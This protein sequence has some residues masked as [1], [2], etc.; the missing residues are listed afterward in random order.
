MWQL[1]IAAIPIVG[2]VPFMIQMLKNA[3][4]RIM[5]PTLALTAGGSSSGSAQEDRQASEENAIEEYNSSQKRSYED[6]LEELAKAINE[7]GDFH[8]YG[9]LKSLLEKLNTL[10]DKLVDEDAIHQIQMVYA[11]YNPIL[12]KIVDVTSP[13]YYGDFV[14]N[15]EHWEHPKEM[16]EQ[17]E[18]AV[19][20]VVEEVAE[21]IRKVNS[22]R[23]V[24]FQVSIESLVG[25]SMELPATVSN[26][27]GNILEEAKSASDSR[28][29]LMN[30]MMLT[31]QA[32][33]EKTRA[34]FTAKMIAARTEEIDENRSKIESE[35]K[36]LQTELQGS[37]EVANASGI[38]GGSREEIARFEDLKDGGQERFNK[39][40]N[41]IAYTLVKTESKDPKRRFI[42]SSL[43]TIT[44]A[45]KS[46]H[47]TN[48]FDGA[49]W[50]DKR[51][52]ENQKQHPYR[53]HCKY[54]EDVKVD[55]PAKSE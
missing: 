40:V 5:S 3:H 46:E 52:L 43:D 6:L 48:E 39:T 4:D 27:M 17:V 49:M 21:D 7:N 12:R 37:L 53:N 23:G 36:R 10:Y 24:N 16:R 15:P 28:T 31:A 34:E 32:E 13:K 14:R 25:S 33:I 19:K 20:A 41:S 54:C 30:T 29:D 38:R 35:K 44:S 42:A 47:F 1:L 45:Y 2:S 8:I 11:K 50:V 55:S 9:Y 22:S 26:I 51:I 18:K